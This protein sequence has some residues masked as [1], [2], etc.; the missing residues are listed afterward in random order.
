MIVFGNPPTSSSKLPFVDKYIVYGN[1][2][3]SSSTLPL[4]DK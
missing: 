2:P 1:P 3:T 4:V